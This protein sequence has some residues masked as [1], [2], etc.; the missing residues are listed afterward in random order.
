MLPSAKAQQRLFIWLFSSEVFDG[1]TEAFNEE[2]NVSMIEKINTLVPT[3]IMSIC[4]I[5]WR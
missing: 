2:L 5:M 1:T 3:G 4:G